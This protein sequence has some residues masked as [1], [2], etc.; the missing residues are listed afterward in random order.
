MKKV[1]KKP[2]TATISTQNPKKIFQNTS[3]DIGSTPCGR[4]RHIFH[5]L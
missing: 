3:G 2:H 5:S 4:W 1:Y